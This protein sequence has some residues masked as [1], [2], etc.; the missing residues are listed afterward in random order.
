MKR[1]T[2]FLISI[3]FNTFGATYVITSNADAGANT[4]RDAITLANANAGADIIN[5]NFG[6]PT[7]ITLATCLPN[8]TETVTINGFSDP[9][10]IAGTGMPVI[11]VNGNGTCGNVLNLNGAGSSGSTIQGLVLYGANRGIYI[12]ASSN[13]N[14]IYGNFIGT[15]SAGTAQAPSIIS[16]SGMELDQSS[17][18]T[19]GGLSLEMRNVISGANE[20]GIR[21][22]GASSNNII[23]GNGIGVDVTGTA[24][25]PNVQRGI[26]FLGASINNLVEN[27]VISGNGQIGI[28]SD[29]CSNITIQANL[30]GI[31]SSGTTA[32]PNLQSGVRLEGSNNSSVISNVISGNTQ[33]GLSTLNSSGLTIQSNM[34]GTNATGAGAV[35]NN[36]IGMRL[37][38]SNTAT[39]TG[40][41]V[42][43]NLESGITLINCTNATIQSNM[44]GTNS[45]GT[46][47][48]A[49]TQAGLRLETCTTPT[50]SNNV[51][52]GNG[53][54]GMFVL[55]C[56]TPSIQT[57]MIGTNITGTAAI[58]NSL[59]GIQ[60][61]TSPN[62][63]LRSNVISG[64]LQNG[65]YIYNSTTVTSI[66][67]NKFGTNA[68]GTAAI[69]NSQNGLVLIQSAGITIENNQLSG[70]NERGLYADNSASLIIQNNYVGTTA[71]GNA[72]LGNTTRGM[73][74]VANSHNVQILNNVVSSNAQ[75]G[76]SMNNNLRPIVKGNKIGLG[77]DGTTLLGNGQHGLEI[78]NCLRP[79][80]GGAAA[81]ESN[82]VSNNTLYGIQFVLCDSVKLKGNYI[83]LDISGTVDC[84][85]GQVG[86][87]ISEGR[88]PI[89]GGILAGEPNYISG[90]NGHG[91]SINAGV[92]DRAIIKGN[93]IGLGTDLS[94][95]VGNGGF[96]I[97]LTDCET[98]QIGGLTSADRNYISKNG[99]N[100]LMVIRSNNTTVEGNYIGVDGTG[101]L[102]RGN[103]AGGI[104][105]ENSNDVMIG[106]TTITARNIVSDNFDNGIVIDGT[107]TNCRIKANFVGLGIDG[108]TSLG[109]G[110]TGIYL[111]GNST[112]TGTIVGGSTF[113]ERNV[114][115]ANGS[116]T[117]TGDGIRIEGPDGNTILGNYCGT[118]STG[119]L[120]RPNYWGG[121]SMNES[122]NNIIGGTGAFE[123]NVCASNMNE[124]IYLR[125]AAN[126]IIIGNYIGTDKSGT[127]QLGNED[128]GI[129]ISPAGANTNNR[130]G[131]SLAERNIIAYNKNVPGYADGGPGVYVNTNS[132]RNTITFNS[133]YC[134]EQK[135]IE[136]NG[137][138]NENLAAPIIVS[139][140]TNDI[141]G[142][143]VANTTI[144]IYR[145]TNTSIAGWCDC[146]G[147]IYVG[148]TTADGSGNWAYTHSLGL[149]VGAASAVTA[150]STNA[151]GSTSAFATCVSP[152]PVDYLSFTVTKL[153]AQTALLNWA[154][155]SE[156]NNDYF[157]ILRS[158]DGINFV[159]IGKKDGRGNTMEVSNYEFTD[160]QVPDAQVVYYR[161]KQVDIDGKFSN[162]V[163]RS[164]TGSG[165]TFIATLNGSTLH[166]GM[167]MNS[168]N[169]IIRVMA[170]TGQVVYEGNVQGDNWIERDIEIPGL[171]KGTYIIQMMQATES[172]SVKVVN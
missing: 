14:F 121:I 141:S 43:G 126:N 39:I 102:P 116:R 13:G 104:R 125:N 129:N 95:A 52:S 117:L 51:I 136:R 91:L 152:L 38:T 57:N 36:Q 119:T 24:A 21:M 109:N 70:N 123:G 41:V 56:T 85:N 42:S 28:F 69:A 162:S 50:V 19:I 27:N 145:N 76:I 1:L 86:V 111:L 105:V 158:T 10:Y 67:L 168:S 32:I 113:A 5:F 72:A 122:D 47:A 110:F 167:L 147:E 156:M 40:N 166:I 64:N 144:H 31:N 17:N 58:A 73:E 100:G 101:L 118:D 153:D 26:F 94:T 108:S 151:T 127:L 114:S 150:T 172:A 89:I 23:R 138:G 90:N 87:N 20:M 165:E 96:G 45:A 77:F 55:N 143:A 137:A 154:T 75:T 18:N 15:N 149:S 115:S 106:G 59:S 140:A 74:I 130:I 60:I 82:Y 12:N 66:R 33:I 49:N 29:N 98:S 139:S 99:S 71:T 48:I 169:A 7:V 22:Q 34:I 46:T 132:H 131:G 161:L 164:I 4:L 148:T 107:S 81:G 44:I 61:E 92:S 62:F 3:C 142:T 93:V 35:P 65:A 9:S 103:G 37:E 128:W 135:G 88:N 30:I 171:S 84:G 8:I 80:V 2:I 160:F 54:Q 11:T 159:E 25:I 79:T 6:V 120:A 133:I 163:I 157:I 78:I 83:G 53:Q 16:W 170:S 124:G 146:E 63:V 68:A 155:A 112:A 97:E 134:N